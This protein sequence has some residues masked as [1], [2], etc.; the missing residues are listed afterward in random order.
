MNEMINIFNGCFINV[1]W[2][3]E[4]MDKLNELMK[5]NECDKWMSEL[6][7]FIEWNNGWIKYTEW[8]N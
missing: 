2:N 7:E 1:K 4:L 6:N 8:M 5:C 3:D